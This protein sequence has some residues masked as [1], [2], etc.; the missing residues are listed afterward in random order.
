M[1]AATDDR[2]VNRAVVDGG[3]RR[4][5][6]ANAADDPELCDFYVPASVQRGPVLVSVSTN[7]ASP[8]LAG[9]VRRLLEALLPPSV[10]DI[11]SFLVAARRRGLKGLARRAAMLRA[12]ASPI[13]N[14]LVERG[15]PDAALDALKKLVDEP[16]E[17]FEPGTVAIVGAGPGD[18]GNLTLRALDRIQRA[19]VVLHDALVPDAILELV[20]PDVR[21]ELV[22]RRS[23]TALTAG[24]RQLTREDRVQRVVDEA[25]AGHRVVRLHGGD[26][27]VFGCAAEEAEALRAEGFGVQ[28]VSGVSSVLAAPAAAGIP[29]TRRGVA[30]GFSVR[31]GHLQTGPGRGA[32][33]V[34]EETVVVLMGLKT[35]DEVAA[36]LRDEGHTPDTPAVAVSHA[37]RPEQ[38]V[39]TGTLATL[40]ARVRQAGLTSPTTLVVG[41]VAAAAAVN[42]AVEAA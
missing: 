29:L 2:E 35:I 27:L 18:V 41:R 17:P 8:L 10:T 15:E 28:F 37:G 7:G 33:P 22:G 20:P 31:T 34:D 32:L 30:R 12:F 24:T 13:V 40:P 14:G 23:P 4:G 38:Q 1:I 36:G 26:A 5:I 6:L 39:V 9:R 16:A 19:D 11:G 25:R 42:A 21:T 3:R